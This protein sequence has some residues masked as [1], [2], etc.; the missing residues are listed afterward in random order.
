MGMLDSVVV[1]LFLMI[2]VFAALIILYLCLRM[3]SIV[4]TGISG[5]KKLNNSSNSIDHG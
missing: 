2:I 5:A 4:F 3:F 1:A